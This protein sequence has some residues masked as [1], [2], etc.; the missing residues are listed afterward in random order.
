ML[1]PESMFTLLRYSRNLARFLVLPGLC[2]AYGLVGLAGQA[3]AA[4]WRLVRMSGDVRVHAEASGNW[5]RATAGQALQPGDSV[6][7]GRAS[8]AMIAT[9]DG[10]V[11]LKARSLVKV[12]SQALPDGMTVLFQGNQRKKLVAKFANLEKLP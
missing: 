9:D 4:D 11:L 1:G 10:T 8:R 7:A 2:V 5:T 3:G 6:W 12:P